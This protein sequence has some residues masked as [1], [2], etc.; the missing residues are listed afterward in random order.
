MSGPFNFWTCCHP[1]SEGTVNGDFIQDTPQQDGIFST[2]NPVDCMN[3]ANFKHCPD[4]TLPNPDHSNFMGYAYPC[5]THFTQGQR[6]WMFACL[7]MNRPYIWLAENLRCTGVMA[8]GNEITGNVSWDMTSVPT[9]YVTIN[10]VLRI[11]PGGTLTIGT[12]ITVQFCET[13]K[14]IVEPNG[15]LNL[16]GI[17]SNACYGRMWQ[18]V[19]VQGTAGSNPTQSLSGA[20]YTQGRFTG[21]P[22][23][24]VENAKVGVSAGPTG[25]GI[26]K[27][28][29]VIFRNNQKAVLFAPFEN[30]FPAGQST[31]ANNNSQFITCSFVTDPGY[32][33]D[34]DIFYEDPAEMLP[35]SVFADLQGVRGI[36]FRGCSFVNERTDLVIGSRYGRGILSSESGF[37]VTGYCASAQPYPA[38]CLTANQTGSYFKNLNEG[39]Y[40]GETDI[41][42]AISKS[43]TVQNAQFEGCWTGIRSESGSRGFIVQNVFTV[44]NVPS[45]DGANAMYGVTLE[46]EHTSFTLQENVFQLANTV[47]QEM[48]D[49]TTMI[50]SRASAIGENDNV[51]RK[52]YYYNLTIGNESKGDNADATGS[53]GLLYLCNENNHVSRYDFSISNGNGV[54]TIQGL[55]SNSFPPVKTSAGNYFSHSAM[56]E[57]DFRNIGGNVVQYFYN[58]GLNQ[59]T[60]IDYSSPEVV[61]DGDAQSR[62]CESILCERPPCRTQSELIQEKQD[63][64]T[65]K[66]QYTSVRNSYLQQPNGPNASTQK[67][68]MSALQ[69]D[70]QTKT[71][72]VLNQLA[73]EGGDRTEYRYWLGNL[74]LYTADLALARDYLGAGEL[75]AA[76]TKLNGIPGKYGLTGQALSAFNDYRAILDLVRNHYQAGGNKFNFSETLLGTLKNYAEQNPYVQVRGLAK[77][78]LAV[79]GILYPLEEE[80]VAG[81]FA[82]PTS[83]NQLENIAIKPNPADQSVVI[84]LPEIYARIATEG[85]VALYNVYGKLH[86]LQTIPAFETTLTLRLTDVPE[87]YYFVQVRLNDGKSVSL[88]LVISH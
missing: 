65:A 8:V 41:E 58:T 36:V 16:Y 29:S 84:M 85:R 61:P 56:L 35:F 48:L 12:G 78:L 45:Y 1:T 74:D 39:I 17:L 40:V 82:W 79:Y 15:H 57:S 25:G 7:E 66:V 22:G 83:A 44:G 28:E 5:Q 26:I 54:R 80:N 75:T 72:D 3:N 34:N 38:P 19:E 4:G 11:K 2:F 77:R 50:G 27:C 62:H 87:G 76:T 24:I 88:P 68:A 47:S 14:V 70:I 18:G 63:I 46:Y 20:V 23:A 6:E 64:N 69:Y 55:Q 37:I 33:G 53:I 73:S 59:E 21:W 32:P 30:H 81:R 67:K 13:A 42:P 52:N 9:G 10:D 71:F 86:L 51:I 43:Y 60:P 31:V 49:I